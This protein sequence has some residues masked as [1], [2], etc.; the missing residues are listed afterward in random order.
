MHGAIFNSIERTGFRACVCFQSALDQV[1]DSRLTTA[2][3]S[4]EQHDAFTYFQT[5]CSRVEIFNDLLQGL[6]DT[7][8]FLAEEIIARFASSRSLDA[9][10]HNHMINVLMSKADYFRLFGG[11]LK[12]LSKSSFPL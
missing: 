10:I 11:N 5:L 12:V 8:D 6:F 9:R 2:D 3:R 4:H 1:N 7:E